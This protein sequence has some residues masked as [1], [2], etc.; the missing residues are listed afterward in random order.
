MQSFSYRHLPNFLRTREQR[1]PGIPFLTMMQFVVAFVVSVVGYGI[2]VPVY[3]V[4][5]I[6]LIGIA[7]MFVWQGEYVYVRLLRIGLAFSR[8]VFNQ[9]PHVTIR[10]WEQEEVIELADYE[11]ATIHVE[12]SVLASQE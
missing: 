6:V 1:I 3:F 11:R 8:K 5:P 7:F 4:I 10:T 2:G 12:G 9:S